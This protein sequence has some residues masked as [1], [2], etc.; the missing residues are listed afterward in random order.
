MGYQKK[1]DLVIQA[2]EHDYER[3]YPVYRSKTER[4]NYSNPQAPVYVVNGAAGNR[5]ANERAPG[6]EPYWPPSLNRTKLI[7]YGLMKITENTIVWE[8]YVSSDN[9]RQD[10]FSMTKT[11]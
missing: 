8:Q 1:V 5:E 2:H 7:S 4:T 11:V 9:S 10:T 6:G 3:T